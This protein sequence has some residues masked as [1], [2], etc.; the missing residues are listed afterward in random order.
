MSFDSL[1]D[2]IG[3]QPDEPSRTLQALS[4]E[5]VKSN[6]T[7]VGQKQALSRMTALLARSKCE[8]AAGKRPSVLAICGPT[9]CGK[10]SIVSHCSDLLNIAFAS[11]D[12]SKNS[13]LALAYRIAS[14]L[15][16][17][18]GVIL[19]R[20]LQTST[21]DQIAELVDILHRDHF[22]LVHNQSLKQVDASN[23]VFVLSITCQNNIPETTPISILLSQTGNI[24]VGSESDIVLAGGLNRVELYEIASCP[25][26][27]PMVEMQKV[28]AAANLQV[29]FSEMAIWQ[30]VDYATTYHEDLYAR[31][32]EYALRVKANEVFQRLM[33]DKGL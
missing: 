30:L 28:F 9:G 10:G 29:E 15:N 13:N 8:I 2:G 12:L 16:F 31:G 6:A 3:E 7:V 25:N 14:E 21:Q 33:T 17:G 27:P 19:I 1:H 20:N 18:A 4:S 5:P 22:V 24:V 26:W 23:F 11:I 32:L